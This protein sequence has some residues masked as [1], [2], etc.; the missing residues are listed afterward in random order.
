M[1]QY[2]IDTPPDQILILEMSM[3]VVNYVSLVTEIEQQ[4]KH[5]HLKIFCTNTI[6]WITLGTIHVGCFLICREDSG[7]TGGQLLWEEG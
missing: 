4:Y 6:Q 1:N 5:S 3:H 2:L 7:S